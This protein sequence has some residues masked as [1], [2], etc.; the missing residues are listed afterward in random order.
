MAVPKFQ[1]LVFGGVSKG[2]IGLGELGPNPMLSIF[3]VLVSWSG[4]LTWSSEPLN[5]IF[6][7]GRMEMKFWGIFFFVGRFLGFVVKLGGV[8]S[9]ELNLHD[10]NSLA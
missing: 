2:A 4:W 9:W 1:P 7:W 3:H 5:S 8:G 10:F 6:S